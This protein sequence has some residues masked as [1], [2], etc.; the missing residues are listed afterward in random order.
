MLL[1]IDNY[2]SFTFNIVQY[3]G[4]LGADVKVSTRR[5]G[6]G[7]PSGPLAVPVRAL[8]AFP[9]LALGGA[10]LLGGLPGRDGGTAWRL[11]VRHRPGRERQLF[12]QLR[13]GGAVVHT[14]GNNIHPRLPTSRQR[15]ADPRRGRR[16]WYRT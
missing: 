3:F 5:T 10:V 7:R 15:R 4:E 2:D 13:G 6:S 1:M 12:Q 11:L 16:Q 14:Y 9:G 8:G